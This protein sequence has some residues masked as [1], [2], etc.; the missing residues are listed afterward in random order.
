MGNCVHRT[1]VEKDSQRLWVEWMKM[2]VKAPCHMNFEV[3]REFQCKN[4]TRNQRIDRVW[5]AKSQ[6]CPV[7]SK[8]KGKRH[9]T[10]CKALPR[11][12]SFPGAGH[13]GNHL[14]ETMSRSFS[15]PA[16][17]GTC[18]AF[19]FSCQPFSHAGD[20]RAGHDER[21]LSLPHALFFS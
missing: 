6:C 1:H 20:Q 14:A 2:E 16:G 17:I 18:V 8:T 4:C 3:H 11:S 12:A 19:G 21:A 10:L 5:L 15:V 13:R 7:C 9:G